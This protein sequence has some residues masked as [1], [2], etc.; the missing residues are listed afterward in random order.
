VRELANVVERTAILAEGRRLTA[1]DLE[2]LLR[3][4]SGAGER[5]RLRQALRD[6]AGDKRRAAEILGVS[7]RTLLRR[8][9]EHDLEGFPKYRS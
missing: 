3:P 5:E 8:V 2:P 9:K 6:A 7:Y 1:A 4:A